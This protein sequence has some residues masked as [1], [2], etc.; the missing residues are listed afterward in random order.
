[1][2]RNLDFLASLKSNS[3]SIDT[4]TPNEQ[5]AEPAAKIQKVEQLASARR[6]FMREPP[7]PES[8][9]LG[10]DAISDIPHG[11]RDEVK[12]VLDMLRRVS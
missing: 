2:K 9:T 10:Y 11:R 12:Q 8:Y 7:P 4:T 3:T 5:Q 6:S 1:M